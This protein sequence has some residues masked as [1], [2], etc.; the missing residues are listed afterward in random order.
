MIADTIDA[1]GN[2]YLSG[3]CHSIEMDLF[4]LL[5]RASEPMHVRKLSEKIGET[6]DKIIFFAKCL[7]KKIGLLRCPIKLE[8]KNQ[9]LM[10][11]QK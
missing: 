7:Q 3:I 2:I 8:I 5:T 10:L 1:G 11:V 4:R 9:K 6:E